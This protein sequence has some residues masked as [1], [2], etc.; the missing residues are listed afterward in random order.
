MDSLKCPLDCINIDE[1]CDECYRMSK[2][3]SNKNKK[4]TR[5]NKYGKQ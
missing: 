5:G 4:I 1:K 3:Y 2:F